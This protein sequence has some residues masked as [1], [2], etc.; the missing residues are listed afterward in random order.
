MKTDIPERGVASRVCKETTPPLFARYPNDLLVA[1][2]LVLEAG[3][4]VIDIP[5]KLLSTLGQE[6]TPLLITL[7]YLRPLLVK[8]ESGCGLKNNYQMSVL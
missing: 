2:D 1:T 5:G 7:H 6:H 4:V 3:N 8:I